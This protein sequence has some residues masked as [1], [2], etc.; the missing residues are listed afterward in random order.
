MR[1]GRTPVG[2]LRSIIR[3]EAHLYTVNRPTGESTGETDGWGEQPPDSF[4]TP[5]PTAK[6]DLFE[7]RESR[8][9]YPIGESVEASL[10]G[11]CL[12]S[13]DIEEYDI[14]THGTGHFEVTTKEPWPDE[15]NPRFYTLT[16]TERKNVTIS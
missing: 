4:V 14:V 16:L 10:S 5:K 9:E 3:M 1:H 8:E 2:P 12:P 13:A 6:L 7:P 11:V 15:D